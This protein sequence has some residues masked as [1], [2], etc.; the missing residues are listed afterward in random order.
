MITTLY[1]G[2]IVIDFD[3][4]KHIFWD[5]Q[6]NRIIGVTS[7]TGIIDKSRPLI[8]WAVGLTRD[9]LIEKLK[10]G[11]IIAEETILEAVKQHTIKKEEAA[12]IGTK[13]HDW[14]ELWIKGKK[15][16]I[17]A[18]SQ[19]MNGVNAFLKWVKETKIKLRSSETIVYSKKHNFAGIMDA[20]GRMG[21]EEV[22]IDFKSSKAIYNE[23]RYQ[24][25]AY[26]LAR[27]E[28]TG[29][30]FDGGWI[31]KFGKDD[32]EF[33]ATYIPRKEYEKDKVAFLAAL[34]IK[35]RENELTKEFNDNGTK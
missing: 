22:I 25:A 3:P 20:E 26:W 31:I 35:L 11:F 1:K 33:A 29:K 21:K 16:E 2:K 13:I 7:V 8:Y 30:K 4:E 15:P 10:N 17:P 5:K 34:A 12:D 14:V 19:V 27:E 32:G 18:E 23:Y 9:F 28:E 24:L 6:S